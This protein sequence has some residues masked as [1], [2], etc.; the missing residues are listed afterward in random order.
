MDPVNT[1]QRRSPPM[2]EAFGICS[3]TARCL[4]ARRIASRSRARTAERDVFEYVVISWDP[5]QTPYPSQIQNQHRSAVRVKR[6]RISTSGALSP[7]GIEPSSGQLTPR[8]RLSELVTEQ[9]LNLY[10]RVDRLASRAS[11]LR[12]GDRLVSTAHASRGGMKDP[13]IRLEPRRHDFRDPDTLT[14]SA[15]RQQLLVDPLSGSD[16]S[17]ERQ[18][19]GNL[20]RWIHGPATIDTGRKPRRSGI[21]VSVPS[22][23]ALSRRE[24]LS[25]GIGALVPNSLS[26]A[27]LPSRT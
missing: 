3:S 12:P 2:I 13:C 26:S 20:D 18:T 6:R 23:S 16:I 15:P 4:S 10:L 11:K 8:G 1:R 27:E 9:R 22:V 5:N 19:S 14:Q 25:S 21:G 7:S 17:L 24:F